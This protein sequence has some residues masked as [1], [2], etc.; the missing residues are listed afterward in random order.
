VGKPLL[1]DTD[2]ALMQRE[3]FLADDPAKDFTIV[4]QQDVEPVL[5]QNAQRRRDAPK[6]QLHDKSGLTLIASIPNVVMIELR[7][8]GITADPVR[9]KAWLNDPE[10]EVFRTRGGKV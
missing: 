9:F 8:K 1:F 5:E 3:V 6:R 4:T 2:P 7:E 10:N